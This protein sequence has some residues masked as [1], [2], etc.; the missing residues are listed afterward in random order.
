M[1]AAGG[2]FTVSVTTQIGCGWQAIESLS[3]VNVTSGSS[4][5]GSGVVTYTVSA[6][7]GKDRNGNL[8]I[9][10]RNLQINQ[11]EAP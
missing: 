4:G 2:S 11:A 6:N 1:P 7:T 5:T 10:G 3:W 9:A 8:A